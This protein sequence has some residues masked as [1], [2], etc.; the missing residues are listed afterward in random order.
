[1]ATTDRVAVITSTGETTVIAAGDFPQGYVSHVLTGK[2]GHES[3]VTL[4]FADDDSTIAVLDNREYGESGP[5]A[6]TLPDV[7]RRI[8]LRV[9]LRGLKVEL[10]SSTFSTSTVSVFYSL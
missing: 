8:D 9:G 7:G 1:M 3:V 5:A 2:P 6:E 4:K 10:V